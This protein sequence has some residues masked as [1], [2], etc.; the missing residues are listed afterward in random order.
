MRSLKSKRVFVTGCGFKPLKHLFRDIITNEPSHIELIHDG[1]SNKIN[2]GTAVALACAEAGAVVR[3]VSRDLQKL[4][5]VKE[6]IVEKVPGA[7]VECIA[8]NVSDE[9][10]LQRLVTDIPSDLPLYWVQSLGVGAGSVV[11][12]DDNPYLRIEN[13]S[14]ELIEAELSVLRSTINLLQLLLPRFEKQEE[15]R[16]CIV[17][18]MSAIRSIVS[19]S[20]HNAAK[21]AMSRFTNAAMIE[22]NKRHI[23]V[24]DVRPGAVDTGM[25]DSLIVQKTVAE[26]GDSYG[27]DWSPEGGGLRLMPPTAVGDIVALILASETHVT[28]VNMVARGQFPHEGS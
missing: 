11:L 17:S 22:L 2:I 16:V 25:Y 3:I 4:N 7:M 24:T 27:Y 8:C 9:E 19:G 14:R 10:S 6:W 5:I 28:S 23:Y 20:I 1:I 15:T 21:G 18:S 26:I 13:I 12:P